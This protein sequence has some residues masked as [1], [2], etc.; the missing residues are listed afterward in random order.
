MPR[1]STAGLRRRAADGQKIVMVTCYDATFAR[2]VERAGADAILVGDSLGMV[3]QGH[4]TTVPVTLD[5]VIYHCRAVARGC[6]KPHLVGDLPFGTYQG[7][8]QDALRA[9]TRLLKEGGVQAVKLE[10][11]ERVV[12]SVRLLTE[13]GIPVMGHLGLTPQSV[14]QFGGWK[15]QGRTATAAERLLADAHALQAAGAYSLVLEG[16]PA[17]LA[18]QVTAALDIPTIGIGAGPHCDGQVLVLYDLLGLDERFCPRFLKKYA[19]LS[20]GVGEAVSA[21]ADEVRT[22]RFPTAAHSHEE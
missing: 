17:P 20:A 7:G 14:H 1:I 12:D 3:I 19:D 21:Y 22:G 4:D 9:A 16:I 6:R 10:G 18:A 2:L 11:G 15:L 13:A 5:D 8:P